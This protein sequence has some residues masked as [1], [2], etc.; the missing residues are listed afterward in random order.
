VLELMEESKKGVW[1]RRVNEK[2]KKGARFNGTAFFFSL[3]FLP[4]RWGGSPG[5]LK[6]SIHNPPRRAQVYHFWDPY[7]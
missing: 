7:P 3:F 5:F 4:T 6:T 1:R 2:I